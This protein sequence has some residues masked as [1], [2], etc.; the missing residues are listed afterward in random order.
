MHD[1]LGQVRVLV[2]QVRQ[3]HAPE[4]HRLVGGALVENIKAR[5]RVFDDLGVHWRVRCETVKAAAAHE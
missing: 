3:L 5:E 4:R 1:L 2:H